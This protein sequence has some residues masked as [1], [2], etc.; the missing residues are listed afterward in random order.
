[1]KTSQLFGLCASSVVP[2]GICGYYLDHLHH[3]FVLSLS[4]IVW[5]GLAAVSMYFYW[6][7]M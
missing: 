6:Q 5:L 2:I 3:L 1:M 4:A 7:E